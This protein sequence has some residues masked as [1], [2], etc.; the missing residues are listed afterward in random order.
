[1]LGRAIDQR[2]PSVEPGG[3]DPAAHRLHDVFVQRL[4]IFERAAGILELHIHLAEL[5][6]QQP[7]QV[8]NGEVGKQVDE[9]YDLQRLQLG[10]RS[11]QYEGMTR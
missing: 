1:M 8:G 6:H 10:M 5:A 9:D 4:Q 11:S 2:Y 3:D 7:G